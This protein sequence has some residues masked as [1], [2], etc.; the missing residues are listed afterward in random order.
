LE[1]PDSRAAPSSNSE[2]DGGA[3]WRVKFRALPRATQ[4]RIIN[5]VALGTLRYH[6]KRRGEPLPTIYVYEPNDNAGVKPGSL[7]PMTLE[8]INE[9]LPWP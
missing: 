7:R 6:A 1:A 3:A 5:R 4:Q 9:I 8:E 2:S